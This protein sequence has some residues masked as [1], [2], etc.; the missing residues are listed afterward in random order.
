MTDDNVE[1]IV[2]R[3]LASE[4]DELPFDVDAEAVHQRLEEHRRGR[5]RLVALAPVAAA[6]VVLV[7]LAG[8]ALIAGPGPVNPGA[9]TEWG[10]LAVVPNTGGAEALTA[11]TLR[12]TELCVW[13]ETAGDEAEL[14]VWPADRTRWDPAM[15]SIGFANSNGIEVTLRDAEPVWFSGGGDSTAESG[16]SG[17]DWAAGLEW[18][19]PPDPSCPMDVRW[20]VNEVVPAAIAEPTATPSPE[21]TGEPDGGSVFEDPNTCED[22]SVGYRVAFPDEWWWNEPFDSEMGPHPNCR[23]FAPDSFDVGTVNREQPIPEGVAIY[24]FVISP[25]GALGQGGALVTSEEVTV[26]GHPA[27]REEEEFTPGGFLAP[28]ERI[29]RYVID[30]PDGGQLVFTASNQVGDYDENRAVLDLMMESLE[31]F[32]P[33]EICG[34]E[35]DRFWCG[36]IVVGLDE[37][38]DV[39]IETVVERNGGD[40]ATDIVERLPEI[41]AYVITVPHG[42]EGNEVSRY[43]TDGAVEY[44]ELNSAEGEAVD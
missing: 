28:G 35:G 15:G 36:Q 37:A 17:E 10:P 2:R 19:A 4:A 9:A 26:A 44:S 5:W 23:Y 43:L 31:L 33:D 25:D 41:G 24:T 21:P 42:T 12:I 6:A 30:L 3:H 11:G 38:A 32:E 39:P 18:V 13:L 16:V 7:V 34:P 14:L 1:D 8:Q 22:D 40:P 27:T 20:F 29:Y